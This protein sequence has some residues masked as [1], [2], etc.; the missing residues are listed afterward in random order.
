MSIDTD[1]NIIDNISADTIEVGDQIIIEGD[2]IEVTGVSETD[3]I[4]EVV[5]RGFSHVTGDSEV[6]SL[7]ADD[8]YDV[9]SI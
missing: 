9:W 1:I 6:Y 7:F 8:Y 3:D 5:I 4:D 2:L